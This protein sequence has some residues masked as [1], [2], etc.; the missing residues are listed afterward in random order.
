MEKLNV[1]IKLTLSTVL[2]IIIGTAFMLIGIF[3]IDKF[4]ISSAGSQIAYWVG[5]IINAAATFM[6]MISVSNVCEE[7]RKKRDK[8]YT[9]RVKAIGTNYQTLMEQG[10]SAQMEQFL[11]NINRA[12]KYEAYIK[13]QRRKYNR[14]QKLKIRCLRSKRLKKIEHDL[15]STP[16]E[17]WCDVKFVRYHKVTYNLLVADDYDINSKEDGFEMHVNKVGLACKKLLFKMLMIVAFGWFVLDIGYT[18]AEFTTAMIL[19]L[20]VKIIMI[21]ISAYSGV[22][23]GYTVMDRRKSVLKN[24]LRI[25]SQFRT[26]IEDTS[27][28]DDNRFVVEIE[29]DAFVEKLKIKPVDN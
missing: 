16:D 21:L 19:P 22:S 28:T 11:Q 3:V 6:I 4:S 9:D 18:F 17:V 25:F 29:K 20:I 1:N 2:S 14:A 23:F 8:N 15:L 10:E 12:N 24:K 5:K 26:R 13:A 27:L 7:S